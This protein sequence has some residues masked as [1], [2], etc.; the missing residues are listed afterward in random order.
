MTSATLARPRTT[1][2]PDSRGSVVVAG[3]LAAT[4]V[5]ALSWALL[6]GLAI[7]G[8]ATA[9]STASA[10]SATRLA[11]QLW[12]LGHHVALHVGG[13]APGVVSFTPLGVTAGIA[14]LMYRG[15]IAA[16]RSYGARSLGDCARTAAAFA[17]PYATLAA[18]VAGASRTAGL[19]AST[20][21][22]AAIPG[23]AAGVIAW[24]AAVRHVGLHRSLIARLPSAVRSVASAVRWLYAGWLVAST[25]LLLTAAAIAGARIQAVAASVNPGVIGS[26]LIAVASVALLPNGVAWAGSY[27]LGGGVAAGSAAVSPLHVTGGPLPALPP[28]AALPQTPP[29][30]YVQLVLAILPVLALAAAWRMERAAATAAEP[31]WAAYARALGLAAGAGALVAAAAAVSGGHLGTFAVGPAPLRDGGLAVA[32]VTVPAFLVVAVRRWRSADPRVARGIN[33]AVGRVRSIAAAV[34]ARARARLR[35]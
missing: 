30:A 20:W 25:L 5:I 16:A 2:A 27:A 22:A 29:T 21:Q 31:W 18:V 6:V 35:G 26:A 17:A 34:L 15:G 28:L 32:A 3:A 7:V 9:G 19:H 1:P 10:A 11:S 23:V 13:A 4:W 33:A 14:A 12:L 24:V 8:W